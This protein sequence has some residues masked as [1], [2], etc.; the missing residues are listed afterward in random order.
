MPSASAVS[1]VCG[2]TCFINVHM[3]A[4]E[5]PG[6]PIRCDYDDRQDASPLEISAL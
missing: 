5:S 1:P 4:M 6:V 3:L 2:R